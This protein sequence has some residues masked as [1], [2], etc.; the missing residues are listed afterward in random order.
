VKPVRKPILIPSGVV[1]A[2]ANYNYTFVLLIVLD[3]IPYAEVFA[4][5]RK[6]FDANLADWKRN[7]LPSLARSNVR[8]FFT[9]G[10]TITE[11]TF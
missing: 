5:S 1:K 7:T 10:K 4:K 6:V 11:V 3:S 9:D 8:F 2:A